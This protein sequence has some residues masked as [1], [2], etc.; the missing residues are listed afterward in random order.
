MNGGES[1]ERIDLDGR[2]LQRTEEGHD[3]IQSMLHFP[4]YYGKNLDALYDLL[5]EIGSQTE[6]IINHSDDMDPM[7]KKVFLNAGIENECLNICLTK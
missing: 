6:M 1:V 4:A 7:F 2:K 3:Y 5:T